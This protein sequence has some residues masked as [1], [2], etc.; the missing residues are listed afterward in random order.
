M[1]IMG[2]DGFSQYALIILIKE[3][4]GNKIYF[5]LFAKLIEGISNYF[6]IHFL[7]YF[8]CYAYCSIHVT[9]T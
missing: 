9:L 1:I 3:S 2:E 8:L 5:F 7:F 4:I 6:S